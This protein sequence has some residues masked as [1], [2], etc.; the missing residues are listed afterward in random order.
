MNP[1]SCALRR[2]TALVRPETNKQKS[3][4]YHPTNLFIKVILALKFMTGVA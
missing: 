2:I 4:E 1:E 3:F